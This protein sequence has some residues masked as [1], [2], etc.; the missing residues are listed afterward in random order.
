[1]I[2]FSTK[3]ESI[4][5]EIINIK[6]TRYNFNQNCFSSANAELNKSIASDVILSEGLNKKL[7][8]YIEDKIGDIEFKQ[9]RLLKDIKNVLKGELEEHKKLLEKLKSFQ[10]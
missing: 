4:P 1:M 8:Q 7:R 10:T 2:N 9:Q 5:Y 6:E 3:F